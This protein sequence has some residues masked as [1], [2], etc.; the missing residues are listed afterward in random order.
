ML[1]LLLLIALPGYADDTCPEATGDAEKDAWTWFDETCTALEAD[2]AQ[3]I[4]LGCDADV[5]LSW[6]YAMKGELA[7]IGLSTLSCGEELS[8]YTNK[9]KAAA[10]VTVVSGDY[11]ENRPSFLTGYDASGRAIPGEVRVVREGRDRTY[12]LSIPAGGSVYLDCNSGCVDTSA[13]TYQVV[14]AI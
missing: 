8:I 4:A 10:T 3:Y 2:K 13:C 14:G 7:S 1:P 5:D 11:C 6:V 9:T 12:S